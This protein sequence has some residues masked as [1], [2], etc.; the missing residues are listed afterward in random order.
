MN[1][2][3]ASITSQGQCQN[4]GLY[5]LKMGRFH[6]SNRKGLKDNI[7]EALKLMAGG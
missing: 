4:I 2:T 5:N 7:L 3:G 6:P 1:I